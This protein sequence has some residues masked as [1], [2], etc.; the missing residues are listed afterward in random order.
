MALAPT[1]MTHDNRPLIEVEHLHLDYP[2]GHVRV[3]VLKGVNLSVKAGSTV[4]VCGPSG[5]GKSS[6]M[7]LLAGLERPSSGRVSVDGVDLGRLSADALADLRRERMGIVFQSFHLLPSLTALVHRPR[8]LLADEPTGNLDDHTGEAVR[9]LLFAL[10]RE[11]GTTLLL[12]THDMDFAARCERTL[13]LHD[14][15]LHEARRETRVPADR[16]DAL[17]A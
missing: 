2:M 7:L 4:A 13:R 16:T 15:V 14:G 8:L 9:D 6:L 1:A 10:N 11:M 17:P 5:S 3:P 12:I